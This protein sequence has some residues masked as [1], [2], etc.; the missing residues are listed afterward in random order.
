MV[1]RLARTDSRGI[2]V[3]R[4]GIPWNYRR[5]GIDLGKAIFHL[6]GLNLRGEVV[7]CKKFLRKQVLHFTANLQVEL[8]GMEA[9]GGAHFLGRALR[10]LVKAAWER[11]IAHKTLFEKSVVQ[12]ASG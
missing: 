1:R 2:T 4:G 12:D 5:I 10:L 6:V 7:V 11:C 3:N 8:M 9:C